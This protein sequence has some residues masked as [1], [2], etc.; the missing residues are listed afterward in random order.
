MAVALVLV[1]IAAAAVGVAFSV[2]LNTAADYREGLVTAHRPL[3]LNPLVGTEDPAVRDIGKLLYRGLLRLDDQAAPVADLAGSYSVSPDGFTYSVTVP[4]SLRW[5]DGTPLTVADVVATVAFV[6]TPGLV[7]L[8]TSLP[9]KG[10]RTT[11]EPPDT[12]RFTLPAPRASFAAFLADFPILPLGRLDPPG[13][14]ALPAHA[15]RPLATSGPYRV[16][17]TD[18]TSLRLESNRYSPSRPR[19][20]RVEFRL[21]GD[22]DSAARAMSRGDVD[23]VVGTTPGQQFRLAGIAGA[24]VHR[25]VTFRFVDLTF[26]ERTPGLEDPAVRHAMTDGVDRGRLVT[27]AVMGA[28]EP[29]SRAIPAAVRWVAGERAPPADLPGARSRLE[30]AG[31]TT[32]SDSVRVRNGVRLAYTLTVADSAPLPEVA[33]EVGRQLAPLG[34][35]ITVQVVPAP[36]FVSTVIVPRAFTMALADWDNGPD[37]DVSSFWRSNASPPQGFNVSGAAPDPF[38]DQ[39]LDALATVTDQRARMEAAGRVQGQLAESAP[40]VFLYAP[41]DALVV[42]DSVADAAIPAVGGSEARFQSIASWGRGLPPGETRD[43]LTLSLIALGILVAL[44]AVLFTG[45]R[46]AGYLLPAEA[47]SSIERAAVAAFL[48]VVQVVAVLQILGAVHLLWPIAVLVAHVLIAAGVAAR[49]PAPEG[50]AAD[51]RLPSDGWL[52]AI[53]AAIPF[54]AL[55]VVEALSGPS[56][57]AETRRV[58]TASTAHWLATHETWSLPFSA[59]GDATSATLPGN[60]DLAALWPMLATHTDELAYGLGLVFALIT[61]LSAALIIRELGGSG[62]K[63]AMAA[64]LVVT[65][66]ISYLTQAS[67]I[68]PDLGVLAGLVFA[69]AMILRGRHLPG[70]RTW[71]VLAGLGLGLAAG[72]AFPAALP[73]AVVGLW[74][75]AATPRHRL[76]TAGLLAA[77]VA[78]LAGFWFL[79]NWVNAG[80]P[81]YPVPL[82][83]AGHRVFGGGPDLMAFRST[84]MLS[85]LVGRDVTALARWAVSIWRLYGLGVIVLAGIVFPIGTIMVLRRRP[86][87]ALTALLVPLL[88]LAY[89]WGPGTGGGP[90]GELNLIAGSLRLSLAPV[91]LALLFSATVLPSRAWLIASAGVL[92]YNAVMAVTAPTRPDLT[93]TWQRGLATAAVAAVLAGVALLAH[94]AA[95][96]WR[97]APRWRAVA[98]GSAAAVAAGAGTAVLLHFTEVPSDTALTRALTQAGRREGLVVVLDDPDLRSVLGGHLDVNVAAAG[99]GPQGRQALITDGRALTSRVE[100]LV[101]AAVVVGGDG[102]DPLPPG[103]RPPS[104]WKLVATIERG[105]RVYVP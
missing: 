12:V 25:L 61:V 58:H 87:A 62:W 48:D 50:S 88:T 67:S 72:S 101:P 29:Q 43:V 99:T 13:V 8:P 82:A 3:S 30:A 98:V 1:A 6:Q 4:A 85:H 36:T 63:G 15:D 33:R 7:S 70:S 14:F 96:W 94:P 22:F 89:V 24:R 16:L 64:L 9:W 27:R 54:G 105:G 56:G 31:W 52:A 93:V 41:A 44:G 19:L 74:A 60:T 91:L 100:E 59:P 83:V 38:L 104:T 45:A 28:G 77:G 73:A 42:R 39:A 26:N 92:L 68:L 53:A 71:A 69:V 97:R 46:V 78:A 76:R 57:E 32:G 66:P 17:G 55:A 51:R 23:G 11:I 75:V 5:S 49:L 47:G 10:I 35:A 90:Q 18:A 65:A 84:P 20:D 80:N 34:I 21:F 103:W 95:D 102:R 37:P 40:A 79:R 81:I 86:G 2:R